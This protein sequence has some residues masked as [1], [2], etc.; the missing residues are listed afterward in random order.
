MRVRDNPL[1]INTLI[2]YY[3]PAKLNLSL[4]H[5]KFNEKKEETMWLQSI[6]K[7]QSQRN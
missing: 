2:T 6:L 5:V 1:N 7:Y 4:I 3:E